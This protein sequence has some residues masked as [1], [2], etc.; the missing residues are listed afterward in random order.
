MAS[1]STWKALTKPTKWGHYAQKLAALK[2]GK[3]FDIAEYPHDQREIS[4]MRAGISMNRAARLIRF[5][6]RRLAGTTGVRI[7]KIGTW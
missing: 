5:T 7:T 1:R 4:K 3:S 2:A 6:V